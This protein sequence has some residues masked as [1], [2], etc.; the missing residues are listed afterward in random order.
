[1]VVLFVVVVV[2]V[3][4]GWADAHATLLRAEACERTQNQGESSRATDNEKKKKRRR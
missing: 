2:A 3:V 4:V 1:M